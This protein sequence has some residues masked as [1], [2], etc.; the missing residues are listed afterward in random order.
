MHPGPSPDRAALAP[1]AVAL[2]ALVACGARP[3]SEPLSDAGATSGDSGT[4]ASTDAGDAGSVAVGDGGLDAGTDAGAS[5]GPDAGSDAGP[6]AATMC[7][8]QSMTQIYPGD[9]PPNPYGS[10]TP[11]GSCA[12]AHDAIILLG[13]PSNTDGT[14]SPSQIARADIAVALSQAGYANEFIVSGAAVHNQY[15]EADA[16]AALLEARGI[17]SSH[18]F[19]DTLAMHTDENI[20]YSD[21]IMEAQG[22]SSA[23]VVSDD[24]GQF[25]AEAICDSNCCVD[26]GRLTLLDFPAASATARVG[27]YVRYPWTTVVSAAE[28]QQIE[29][30]TKAMCTLL[31][32][33][34]ACAADFQLPP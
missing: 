27:H 20:Y 26:L 34:K 18:I 16:L 8:V 22:W 15:V 3:G 17:A 12:V 21:K 30:P 2:L 4:T 11:A 24:P 33:R 32:S 5:D 31:S 29:I 25:T 10:V 7:S 14:P 6:S 9:L 19:R 23:I 13:C 1:L 28:C